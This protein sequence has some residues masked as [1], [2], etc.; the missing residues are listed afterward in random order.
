MELLLILSALLSAATGAF[1]GTRGPEVAPRHE[2]AVEAVAVT[3]SVAVQAVSKQVGQARVPSGAP[4][5]PAR[6]VADEAPALQ[7]P[8]ETDR[9]I[10]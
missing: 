10:E 9:L 7:V 2:A 4:A 1:T 3:E 5:P 8:L 6:W